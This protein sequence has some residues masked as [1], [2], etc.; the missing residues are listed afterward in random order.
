MLAHLPILRTMQG[1]EFAIRVAND[2][3]ELEEGQLDIVAQII[4]VS[5]VLPTDQ[6]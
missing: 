4:A 6:E 2:F 1:Q 5:L 3:Q